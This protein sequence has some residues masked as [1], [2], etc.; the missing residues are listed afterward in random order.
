MSLTRAKGLALSFWFFQRPEG[1]ALKCVKDDD[2]NDAFHMEG[3]ILLTRDNV[4]Y[5]YEEDGSIYMIPLVMPT[6]A[7]KDA[8]EG[9]VEDAPKSA[10][11]VKQLRKRKGIPFSPEAHKSGTMED[12]VMTLPRKFIPANSNFSHGKGA[13]IFIDANRAPFYIQ[14]KRT[15]VNGQPHEE[16]VRLE[17]LIT[18]M[19]HDYPEFIKSLIPKHQIGD[20]LKFAPLK[21]EFIRAR[22]CDPEEGRFYWEREF[23]M[24]LA[25]DIVVWYSMHGASR[26][27]KLLQ[28]VG[29][30]PDEKP[31]TLFDV[32]A[33]ILMRVQQL[34]HMGDIPG[35]Q[36]GN[37]FVK[38]AIFNAMNSTANV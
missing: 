31:V 27:T 9:A 34:A 8:P 23:L 12:T 26:M 15:V 3:D 17:I 38:I 32:I 14:T 10:P 6:P 33:N 20:Q 21:A 22:E 16:E 5:A 28:I 35:Q 30:Y 2:E 1:T 18:E 19:V 29:L 25:H 24:C 37:K 7:P 11:E 36:G 13:Y 4:K